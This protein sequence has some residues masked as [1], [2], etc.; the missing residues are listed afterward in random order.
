[1]MKCSY[2]DLVGHDDLKLKATCAVLTNLCSTRLSNF[3]YL[4]INVGCNT[5]HLPID[6]LCI[7]V[8]IISFF[9]FLKIINMYGTHKFV[10]LKIFYV[11]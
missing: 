8:L 5:H 9:F 4:F 7:P 6:V 3:L 10:K 2:H 11:F 1:M